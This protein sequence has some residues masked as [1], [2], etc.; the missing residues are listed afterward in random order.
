MYFFNIVIKYSLLVSND[1]YLNS[2]LMTIADS[3]L[4]WKTKKYR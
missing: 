1:R 2:T 3:M 4:K